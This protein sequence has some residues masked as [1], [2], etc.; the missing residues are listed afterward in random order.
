MAECFP[1]CHIGNRKVVSWCLRGD[2]TRMRFGLPRSG[3]RTQNRQRKNHEDKTDGNRRPGGGYRRDDRRKRDRPGWNISGNEFA[4]S[5]N[6]L[7]FKGA[8][9]RSPGNFALKMDLTHTGATF[10]DNL[11]AVWDIG[12][13]D[14]TADGGVERWA[15]RKESG[16]N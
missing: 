2:R 8:A 9:N 5:H 14:G 6:R 12:S 7:Q 11:G 3:K 1:P 16:R 10:N 13:N 4:V 15:C